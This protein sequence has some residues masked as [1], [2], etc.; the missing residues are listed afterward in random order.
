[1]KRYSFF[2]KTVLGIALPSQK[3][4]TMRQ[5]VFLSLFTFFT[6]SA[7]AQ[8]Y[9]ELENTEELSVKTK[10]KANKEGNKELYVKFKNTAK[11]RLQVSLEIGFYSAGVLA[12]KA[13]ISDCLKKCFWHNWFRPIQLII[14]EELNNKEIEREDFE[15]K[16]LNLQTEK[17]EECEE[18]HE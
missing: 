14:P 5:I 4:K 10:W 3:N 9:Q 2:W 15:F 13:M 16:I 7:S 11:S 12:E 8:S 18:T 1:M 17:V 6:L